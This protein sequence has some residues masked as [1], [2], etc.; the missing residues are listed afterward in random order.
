LISATDYATE[1]WE[2]RASTIELRI[3]KLWQGSYFPGFLE[4]RGMAE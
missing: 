2:T 1:H 4:P 3:P